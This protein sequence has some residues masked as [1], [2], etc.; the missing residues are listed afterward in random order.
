[1]ENLWMGAKSVLIKQESPLETEE[2]VTE[3]AHLVAEDFSVVAGDVVVEEDMEAADLTTTEVE[4]MVVV[5]G[6][7]ME[8]AGV[9]VAMEIGLVAP[10]ETAMTVMLQTSKIP[11]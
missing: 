10:T 2:E 3:E 7:T 4:D 5:P 8:V 6:T 1:M 9:R 11:S